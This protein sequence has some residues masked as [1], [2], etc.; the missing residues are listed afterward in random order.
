MTSGGGIRP[1]HVGNVMPAPH[2]RSERPDHAAMRAREAA[3]A[4]R[5]RRALIADIAQ[6]VAAP[7]CLVSAYEFA[8][9]GFVDGRW[10]AAVILSALVVATAPP[11]WSA[12]ESAVVPQ[13]DWPS[14]ARLATNF[15]PG[16]LLMLGAAA[17]KALGVAPW[18][19]TWTW[20][21]GTV[22][23]LTGAWLM[24]LSLPRLRPPRSVYAWALVVVGVATVLRAWHM[25]MVPRYVHHD[26]MVMSRCGLQYFIDRLDPFT[27]QPGAGDF[28]NMPLAFIPAGIGVWI[29]GLNLFWAR[30]PDVILGILSVWL[31]F[32]GLWRV[33]TT[34]LAVVAA[35][36]LAAN[37]CHIAYSRIASTY[38]HSAFFVS[39]LFA[40]FSRLWTAPTYVTAVLLGVSGVLGMQT[41]HASFAT[42]PLLIAAMLLL[43]LLQPRRW[44]ALAA[45]LAIFAVSALCAA[46]IFGVALWQARD[47]MF[48]RNR[49]VSIFAPLAMQA[50]KELYHTDSAAV[51]VARQ[52]W[53]SLQAFHFGRD[54][55][56][57]YSIDRPLADPYSAALVLVGAVLALAR[58]RGFVSANAFVVTAGYLILGLGMQTTTC[59]NRVTGALP[60]GMVFPAIA[61]V[62]C[63]AVLWRGRRWPS[64]WLRDLSIAGIAAVCAVASLRTYFSYYPGAFLYGTEDS[65]A[66]WVAREYA[67]RYTV[68]LV[69]WSFRD[70]QWDSQR[71]IL[72]DVPV[73]RND[74][75]SDAA[76]IQD[77]QVTGSDLFIV[78]GLASSSRDALLARFP[79]A[80]AETMRRHPQGGPWLYLVFVGE[81]RPRSS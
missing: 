60:L 42:L 6:R 81:P 18:V 36:L 15:V 11:F 78:S 22:W 80:R 20:L 39:L 74:K 17:G 28:T 53:N 23:L 63:S 14:P 50:L 41:Y 59:H 48:V 27:V 55:C 5:S 30:L 51:V 67:D 76:Y 45:P 69:S 10:L 64:R 1:L 65:E 58:L 43:A 79:Q 33:S 12:P 47:I 40:L 19:A 62:Q 34:R 24:S 54:M 31:L 77:V 7:I 2:S 72:A 44:R 8:G 16:W 46:G 21:T 52:A 66:A 3:P 25:D 73:D 37:H 9:T 70:N 57:Q 68:H 38:I 75:D 49:E 29:G 61:I 56:E 4:A 35:L 13:L 32:D 26:E 71:L